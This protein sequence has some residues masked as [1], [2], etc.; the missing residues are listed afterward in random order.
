VYEKIEA[1]IEKATGFD[2]QVA[3]ADKELKDTEDDLAKAL[4]SHDRTLI[5]KAQEE[6]IR[7][8]K[9]LEQKKTDRKNAY[10]R[11]IWTT[12]EYLEILPPTQSLPTATMRR[13]APNKGK[14]VTWLPTFEDVSN[15]VEWV[16]EK[17]K[18]VPP[19][20]LKDVLG[21]TNADGRSLILP[22]AF[23]NP[24][25][26]VSGIVHELEHFRQNTSESRSKLGPAEMEIEAYKVEEKLINDGVLVFPET[27]PGRE[28]SRLGQI[29]IL[30]GDYEKAAER[31]RV[32]RAAGKPIPRHDVRA[33]VKEEFDKIKERADSLNKQVRREL[34]FHHLRRVARSACS[35]PVG[36][37][38][39]E[40]S[41]DFA[42]AQS[43]W[44][45]GPGPWLYHDDAPSPEGCERD[46]L[47]LLR[48]ESDAASAGRR[49]DELRSQ[50][51]DEAMKT[52]HDLASSICQGHGD[53]SLFRARLAEYRSACARLPS[54]EAAGSWPDPN[55]AGMARCAQEATAVLARCEEPEAV[56]RELDAASRRGGGAAVPPGPTEEERQK[57]R[58]SDNDTLRSLHQDMLDVCSGLCAVPAEA[59]N[60][61]D[62]FCDRRRQVRQ[63]NLKYLNRK[64]SAPDV[65][66][67]ELRSSPCGWEF[68]NDLLKSWKV[69]CFGDSRAEAAWGQWFTDKARWL[70][71]KYQPPPQPAPQDP[72]PGPSV[73]PGGGG[74]AGGGSGGSPETFCESRGCTYLG[75]G[76]CACPVR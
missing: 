68:W 39:G 74:G 48:H 13:D 73:P 40:G 2:K 22:K 49:L 55:R 33:P 10:D 28:L 35:S 70:N 38:L 9:A 17:G 59:W 45:A 47:D 61:Y 24:A 52:F 12:V 56:E 3:S 21:I 25:L 75:P 4:G 11:A 54:K 53:L 71:G 42:K 36:A 19:K 32:L 14:P 69:M 76:R 8:K 5:K 37:G 51:M 63:I 58:G 18:K 6:V 72:A 62:V 43:V 30:K 15:I 66:L 1:Q 16:N 41:Q 46:A 7:A 65:F 50:A 67:G 31:E 34:A 23:K 60:K 29:T 26:L 64:E 27:Q 20:D 44:P 57:E